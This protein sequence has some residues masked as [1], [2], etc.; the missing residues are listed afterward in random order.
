MGDVTVDFARREA[1]RGDEKIDLTPREFG[2]LE[3]LVRQ[4]GRVVSRQGLLDQVW[5]P[6]IFISDRTVDTH[7]ANLRKKVEAD[8]ARPRHVVS[9]RGIGYRFDP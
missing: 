3:V 5:S 2:I 4:Q 9:V 1:K 6:G 8:P 7:V